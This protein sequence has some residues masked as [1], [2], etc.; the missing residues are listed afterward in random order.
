MS[1]DIVDAHDLPCGHSAKYAIFGGDN[2]C[3]GCTAERIG[4]E[5][6][7]LADEIERLRD[8]VPI[9]E[10]DLRTAYERRLSECE[11]D[12]ERLRARL[13]D[14]ERER[15][16]AWSVGRAHEET[17][18]ALRA[19]LAGAE[20]LLREA[21]AYWRAYAED[22]IPSDLYLRVDSF[23]EPADSAPTP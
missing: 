21:Q 5:R 19:R 16:A 3:L 10:V 18:D 9:D 2:G 4:K 1:D 7:A 11:A 8:C 14:V 17:M 23:L 20:A 22:G 6:D 12:N 15:D 13:A